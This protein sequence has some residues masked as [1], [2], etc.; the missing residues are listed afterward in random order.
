MYIYIYNIHI[1]DMKNQTAN[2]P[3]KLSR[4]LFLQE[5]H[6]SWRWGL[7]IPGFGEVLYRLVQWYQYVEVNAATALAASAG[8]A[9]GI[10]PLV[11]GVVPWRKAWQL[12][13]SHVIGKAS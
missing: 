3:K 2:E 10:A 5:L 9:L 4:F 1:D 13:L 12:R 7:N 8:L 11:M 6:G